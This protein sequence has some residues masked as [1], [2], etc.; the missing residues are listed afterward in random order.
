MGYLSRDMVM[1]SQSASLDSPADRRAAAQALAL[2]LAL[3]P[4]NGEAR[5]N[6][7]SIAGGKGIREPDEEKL[8]RAKARIWQF[9][10]W[11]ATPEAGTDGNL[12]ADLIRDAASMLDP[13]NRSAIA[14]RDAPEQG[15]WDDWVAPLGEFQEKEIANNDQPVPSSPI[16]PGVEQIIAGMPKVTL[17][18]A[19]VRT[20]LYVYDKRLDEYRFGNTVVRMKADAE[21]GE[22]LEIEVPSKDEQ[23]QEVTDFVVTRIR[24]ALEST[25]GLFLPPGKITLRAGDGDEYSFRKNNIAITGP[26]FVLANAALTG[27]V[28]D[29]TVIGVI[30]GDNK[31]IAPDYIYYFIEALA[32][33]DGGRLVIPAAAAESFAALLTLE[34]P[35]FFLKYEVLTAATPAEF[36]SLCA[37]SPD[38]KYASI[39]ARFKEIKDKA[40]GTSLGPYLAN[41]FVR[42]RLLDISAEAPYHLSAKLLAAQGSS[43]R[44]PRTVTRKMLAALVWHAIA[45]LKKAEDLNPDLIN[46]STAESLDA[47]YD[48]ARAELDLL[49]R[50]TERGD[51]ELLDRAKSVTSDFRDLTRA[52][53]SRGDYDT[54]LYEIQKAWR[55]LV[56]SNSVFRKELS[57]LTGDP[58]PEEAVQRLRSKRDRDRDKNK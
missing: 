13:G 49:D 31:L 51:K 56:D 18:E 9:L 10:G 48:Q 58:L 33:G 23:K 46:V 27:D 2:A 41:K 8:T 44:P 11:L 21:H 6:L 16:V 36:A 39:S 32:E 54:R 28:P 24:G 29:T 25:A 17:L 53:R 22:G 52:L 45:P 40:A 34:K 37:K 19:S 1:L 38:E 55:A 57:L 7:S 12:L 5:D 47:I 4:A 3:D 42:Q 14:L 43:E 15:K 35:D 30:D 20:V 50:Y 26:G